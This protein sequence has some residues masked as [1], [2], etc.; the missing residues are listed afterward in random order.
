M[1]IKQVNFLLTLGIALAIGGCAS[2]KSG[3]T[4]SRDE[5]R[6]VQNVQIGTVE[7]SRPVKIE[8]TKTAIGSGAGTI[9][10]AIAGSSTGQGKGSTIG[11]VIGAV[12]GGVVGAA[13]E[14]GITRE[15]G[16]EVTVRLE[17]GRLISVVQAGKEQFQPGDKVRVLEG[18]GG[19]RITH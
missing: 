19:T 17:S 5:A 18:S 1:G 6:Q 10:G 13:A 16:V 15:D 3:D 7:A 2:S 4:Y 8:G 9:V 14:E 12:A 11:S